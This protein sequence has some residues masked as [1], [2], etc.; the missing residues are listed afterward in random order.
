MPKTMMMMMMIKFACN[1]QGTQILELA[2]QRPVWK[3]IYSAEAK[4]EL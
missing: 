1:I 3:N 4:T 2:I